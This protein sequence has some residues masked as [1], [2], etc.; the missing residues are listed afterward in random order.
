MMLRNTGRILFEITTMAQQLPQFVLYEI[1]NETYFQGWHTISTN[2]Y[3][4]L[5][6]LVLPAWYPDQ[7]PRDVCRL[8]DHS[9]EVRWDCSQLGRSIPCLPYSWQRAG[10][11]CPD[12]P[13]QG[14]QLGCVQNLCGHFFQ[15]NPLAGG[16]WRPS[17]HRN[18]DR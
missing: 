12:L 9:V 17:G 8:S 18:N 3:W 4:Y 11:V 16:I 6:K 10:R 5:L 7:M 2:G 15:R 13:F 1:G 14:R